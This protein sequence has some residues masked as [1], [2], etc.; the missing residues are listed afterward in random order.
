MAFTDVQIASLVLRGL[1]EPAVTSL[2]DSPQ[3]QEAYDRFTE[4]SARMQTQDDFNFTQAD[5]KLSLSAVSGN[6]YPWTSQESVVESTSLAELTLIAVDGGVG[7]FRLDD[8]TPTGGQNLTGQTSGAVRLGGTL[9]S[10]L[11][12]DSAWAYSDLPDPFVYWIA[13]EAARELQAQYKRSGVD[14][15]L[16]AQNAGR[17][18][19]EFMEWD[20]KQGAAN[21]F[22]SPDP[23]ASRDAFRLGRLDTTDPYYN[24]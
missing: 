1:N 14:D 12:R 16:L 10:A 19:A 11:S 4:I 8:G 3:A 9:G 18:H 6:T 23:K 5:Y 17:K 13:A 2:G 7:W 15:A 21:M 22:D 24:G 20:A